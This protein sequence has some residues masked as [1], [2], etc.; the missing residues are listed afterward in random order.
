MC[1]NPCVLAVTYKPLDTII[2]LL[3]GD[4]VSTEEVHGCLQINKFGKTGKTK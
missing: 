2:S 4:V 3:F 1:L